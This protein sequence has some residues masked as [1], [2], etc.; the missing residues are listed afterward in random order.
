MR[1]IWI[2]RILEL[3]KGERCVALKSVSAGEDVL[4]DQFPVVGRP[5][6]AGYVRPRPALPNPLVLEGMAQTS[7]VLVGHARDFRERVILAKVGKARFTAVA[8]PGFVLRHTATLD[9]IDDIGATARI[10][11]DRLEPRT[12]E[13]TRLAEAELM[14]SHVTPERTGLD[15]PDHNFVFTDQLMDLLR[16]SGFA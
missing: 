2:D 1:W 16:R 8:E 10:R 9:R 4:H 6:E 11:T 5:G 14:F 3:T 7:G 15:M 12:G 13:P